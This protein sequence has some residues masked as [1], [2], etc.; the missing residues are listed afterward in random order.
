MQLQ[1]ARYL[2]KYIDR[3]IRS[4]SLVGSVAYLARFSEPVEPLDTDKEEILADPANIIRYFEL[5]SL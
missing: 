3:A 2:L 4:K 1:V 5:N